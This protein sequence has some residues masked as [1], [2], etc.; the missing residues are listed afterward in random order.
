MDDPVNNILE[1]RAQISMN[2]Y[3]VIALWLHRAILA[4]KWP[5]MELQPGLV[6]LQ[7]QFVLV[8][9]LEQQAKVSS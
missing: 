8:C 4:T 6:D 2:F 1:P 9:L 5:M 3:I 7:L